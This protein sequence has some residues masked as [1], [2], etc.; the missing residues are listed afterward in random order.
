MFFYNSAFANDA[1]LDNMALNNGEKLVVCLDK[2]RIRK[3][4]DLTYP[5]FRLLDEG[6]M[7]KFIGEVSD[8]VVSVKINSIILSYPFYKVKLSDNSEGWVFGGGVTPQDIYRDKRISILNPGDHAVS[9]NKLKLKNW[10]G[11]FKSGESFSLKKV[12]LKASTGTAGGEAYS[13]TYVTTD[14]GQPVILIQNLDS[15]KVDKLKTVDNFNKLKGVLNPKLEFEFL[16]V[17]Y[18]LKEEEKVILVEYNSGYKKIRYELVLRRKEK[19]KKEI[20]QIISRSI[21]GKHTIL[22]AGDIDG[23]NKLD[24]LLDRDNVASGEINLLLSSK[25]GKG[26]LLKMIAATTT[27]SLS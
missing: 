11:L 23:D 17:K 21:L 25:A 3:K 9:T 12:K 24:I 26:I 6:K 2:L 8:D 5:S 22:W 7:V 18:E 13:T 27:W 14:L 4:A 10:F 19:N 20:S 16:G 1:Y 15:K